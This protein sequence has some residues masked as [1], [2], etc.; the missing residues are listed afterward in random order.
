ME[1][2][3][4][5]QAGLA[6]LSFYREVAPALARTHGLTYPVELD[7]LMVERLETLSHTEYDEGNRAV[8]R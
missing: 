7:R 2:K 3:A 4:L 5:Y 6:I 8:A 1:R